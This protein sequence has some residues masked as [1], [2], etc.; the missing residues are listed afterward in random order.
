MNNTL[1]PTRL[2]IRLRWA[3]AGLA[4]LL[5][6]ALPAFA[7]PPV[8]V[9]G[10]VPA[11][12]AD[13]PGI[14]DRVDLKQLT[15]LNIAFL[16]PDSEG[17]LVQNGK[18]VCMGMAQASDLQAVV[19]KAHKTGVK[20]LVSLA[21]GEIPACSGN[22]QDL[23]QPASRPRLVKNLLGFV[24]QFKLDGIDV[25]LEGALLTA[26]DKDGNYTPFV[27]ALRQ[28]LKGQLLTAATATYEGGMVP[29]SSL[30]SFDFVTLMAYDAIGPGWGKAGDEHAP[31]AMAQ[32]HMEV[33]KSRGLPK[34]KMVLGLPLYGY[35]FNGY[36]QNYDVSAIVTQFGAA[37]T[38]SDVVG[39]RC[40]TCAY[41]NYNG[42]PTIRAK[43]RL[44]LKEGAGVMVWELS[45]DASGRN[46]LMAVIRA[47]INAIQSKKGL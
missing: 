40:A 21:G 29:V 1:T 22:W 36:D 44:A 37:A 4:A 38:Q 23:L 34:E 33:W 5:A 3:A 14:V 7:A 2:S 15:H 19:R 8:K 35:G 42:I 46:S 47:E 31:Y 28:G 17:N 45:Q 43:T 41:I 13:M 10:Y 18:P 26:I 25:D 39:T 11:F 20:V 27:Q 30:P 6:G 24:Q 12:K 9:V 16:N 32:S